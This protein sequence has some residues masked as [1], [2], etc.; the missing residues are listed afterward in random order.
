MSTVM[1]IMVSTVMSM[2]ST[3]TVGVWDWDYGHVLYEYTYI[4]IYT[5]Q[6][7]QRTPPHSKDG[8][9][10][11]Q[12]SRGISMFVWPLISRAELWRPLG[13]GTPHG[14]LLSGGDG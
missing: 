5:T 11:K 14:G 2:V 1:S 6:Y 9:Q 10:V 3:A 8:K 4:H 7:T 12:P 13:R